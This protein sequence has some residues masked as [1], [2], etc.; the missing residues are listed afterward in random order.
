M[1]LIEMEPF[2]SMG[3][4]KDDQLIKI[5]QTR[6]VVETAFDT[7]KDEI[8]GIKEM[9]DGGF[10]IIKT[11]SIVPPKIEPFNIIQHK[12]SYRWLK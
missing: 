3:L 10:F 7:E 1:T 11:Q 6:Q 12:V 9:A 5:N 2:N 4:T 8:S